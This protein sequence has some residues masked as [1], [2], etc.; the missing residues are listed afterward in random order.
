MYLDPFRLKDC[1]FKWLAGELDD[2]PIRMDGA[3]LQVANRPG[4]QDGNFHVAV[5]FARFRE[6]LDAVIEEF[7][8]SNVINIV[9]IVKLDRGRAGIAGNFLDLLVLGSN[10]E[11]V[12]LLGETQ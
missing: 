8:V 9:G 1:L 12:F 3:R 2:L 4:R 10:G 5:F 11:P 7:R 6:H